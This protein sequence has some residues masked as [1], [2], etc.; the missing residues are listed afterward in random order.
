MLFKL[1]S[2]DIF[3]D[4]WVKTVFQVEAPSFERGERLIKKQ[5][6]KLLRSFPAGQLIGDTVINW[7]PNP[8]GS[9]SGSFVVP[10][11]GIAPGSAGDTSGMWVNG[12]AVVPSY[13]W[14]S[15][16]QNSV[17]TAET[18]P[19][20]NAS[21]FT[22]TSTNGSTATTATIN[23]WVPVTIQPGQT[24]V[25]GDTSTVTNSG[26]CPITIT[27]TGVTYSNQSSVNINWTE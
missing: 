18:V 9:Y 7:Q 15:Q 22:V 5:L 25:M 1:V 13:Q 14:P 16:M 19:V 17:F 2:F 23:S 4:G 27:N 26:T 20:G 21:G 11:A 10:N 8:D 6:S 24:V 12:N 3:D